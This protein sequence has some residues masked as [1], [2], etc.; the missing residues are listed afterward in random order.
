MNVEGKIAE[1]VAAYNVELKEL[2]KKLI[3]DV[4]QA[5]KEQNQKEECLK[6]LEFDLT[7]DMIAVES[8]GEPQYM[9]LKEIGLAIRTRR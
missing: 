9:T 5:L 8:F 7:I 3:L 2:T 1:S 6:L 4:N